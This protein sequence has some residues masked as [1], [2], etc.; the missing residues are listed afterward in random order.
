MAELWAAF[1]CAWEVLT[2]GATV[3]PLA[4]LAKAGASTLLAPLTLLVMLT[5]AGAFTIPAVGASRSVLAVA[6]AATLLAPLA[7]LVMLALLDDAPLDWMRRWGFRRCRSC[8][9]CLHDG[10]L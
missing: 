4:V 7:L 6:G 1:N 2:L 5:D 8:W 10:E 9:G 3:A